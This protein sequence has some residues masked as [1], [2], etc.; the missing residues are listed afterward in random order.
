[1]KE[2]LEVAAFSLLTGLLTITG[3]IVNKKPIIIEN[4]INI[5]TFQVSE[6]KTDSLFI[7]TRMKTLE[8]LTDKK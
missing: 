3:I 7:D 1:M 6:T 8:I 4:K 2:L 5:D